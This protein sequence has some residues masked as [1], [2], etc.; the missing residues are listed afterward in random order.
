MKHQRKK[1]RACSL[2]RCI[3]HEKSVVFSR[4]VGTF[5]QCEL[6]KTEV[7]NFIQICISVMSESLTV[8]VQMFMFTWLI[9]A[10]PDVKSAWVNI[11]TAKGQSSH[12][13]LYSVYGWQGFSYR[14]PRSGITL[15]CGEKKKKSL[16][17]GSLWGL[18][19]VCTVCT[20]TLSVF[21]TSV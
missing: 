10:A 20:Y 12:M 3:K 7:Y 15:V 13:V 2:Q 4:N 21:I 16:S 19:C 18:L 9:F 5:H 17:V 11:F 6:L 1:M 14:R 8:T